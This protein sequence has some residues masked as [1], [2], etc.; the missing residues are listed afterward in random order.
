MTCRRDEVID[1]EQHSRVVKVRTR[2]HRASGVGG[3]RLQVENDVG[4]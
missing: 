3:L 1:L 4:F 2:T